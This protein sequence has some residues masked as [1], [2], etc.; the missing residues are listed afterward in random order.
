MQKIII[1]IW[2][3]KKY[4]NN[5][6]LEERSMLSDGEN[7]SLLGSSGAPGESVHLSSGLSAQLLPACLT[8]SG[9]L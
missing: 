1:I 9:D 7:P 4:T 2:R 3:I 5:F 6:M 8:G